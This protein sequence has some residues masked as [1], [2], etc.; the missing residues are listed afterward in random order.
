MLFGVFSLQ[1][2]D[3]LVVLPHSDEIIANGKAGGLGVSG[4]KESLV[5]GLHRFNN[6]V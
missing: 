5:L 2:E 6:K 3:L 4:E 1:E